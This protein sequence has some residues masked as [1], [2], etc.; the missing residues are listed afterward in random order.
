M[1]DQYKLW[2]PVSA[3]ET[4][5]VIIKMAVLHIWENYD[6]VVAQSLVGLLISTAFI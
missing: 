4:L 2:S 1:I 5:I 3:P 6:T